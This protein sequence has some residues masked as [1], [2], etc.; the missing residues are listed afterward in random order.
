MGLLTSASYY[1]PNCHSKIIILVTKVNRFHAF[2]HNRVYIEC[3]GKGFTIHNMLSI[4]WFSIKYCIS[5]DVLLH[6]TF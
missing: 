2:M 5:I 6:L 4:L 3:G 1:I